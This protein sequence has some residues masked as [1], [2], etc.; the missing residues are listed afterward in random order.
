MQQQR[1]H[2]T[3]SNDPSEKGALLLAL[4]LVLLLALLLALLLQQGFTSCRRSQGVAETVAVTVA[5]SGASTEP[6]Y[7]GVC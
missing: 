5:E 4:P 3:R 2:A 1:Q 6:T 7:A